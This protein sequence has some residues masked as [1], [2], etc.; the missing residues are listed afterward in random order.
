MPVKGPR[1][2]AAIMNA[3]GDLFSTK[4]YAA[5][6]LEEIG[7][8]LGVSRGTVLFHFDTKLALLFAVVEPLQIEVEAMVAEFEKHSI[9]LKARQRRAFLSRYAEILATHPYAMRLLVRDLSSITQLQMPP[10]GPAITARLMAL[11]GGPDPDTDM[12]LRTSAALGA[13][14]RPMAVPAV[15]I[16]ASARATLVA[17]ALAAYSS[18]S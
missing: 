4:G 5:T 2:R 17:C 12:R 7:A 1:T 16:D 15:E 9:P 10:S 18:K 6:S 8:Q 3:A 11:L 13:I 14:L